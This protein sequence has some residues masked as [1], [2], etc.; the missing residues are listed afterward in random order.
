MSSREELPVPAVPAV[1][2]PIGTGSTVPPNGVEPGTAREPWE[3]STGGDEMRAPR[4]GRGGRLAE[5]ARV[6]AEARLTVA[7][8]RSL[9]RTDAWAQVRKGTWPTPTE[10]QQRQGRLMEVMK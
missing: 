10:E 4:P 7:R 5:W 1:P 8:L 2:E 3:L 6:Q 9:P